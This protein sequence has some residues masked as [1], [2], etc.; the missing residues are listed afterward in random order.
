MARFETELMRL[1]R[2]RRGRRCTADMENALSHRP[3]SALTV[4]I[5]I[6]DRLATG[7]R[8]IGRRALQS[9]LMDLI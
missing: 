1:R 6:S 3:D 2:I 4:I 9:V 8:Q 5:T 7:V